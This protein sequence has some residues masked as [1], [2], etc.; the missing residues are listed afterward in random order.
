[1]ERIASAVG[2]NGQYQETIHGGSIMRNLIKTVVVFLMGSLLLACGGPEDREGNSLKAGDQYVMTKQGLERVPYLKDKQG[3]KVEVGKEY[4]MTPA[5]LELIPFL[6]DQSGKR[7]EVG[8]E[9][10]VGPDGLKLVRSRRV[11]GAVLDSDGKPV[12]GVDV[13]LAQTDYKATTDSN[14]L[15]SL[16]FVEGYVKLALGASHIPEWCGVENTESVFLNLNNYPEGWNVGSIKLP[17][18]FAG[19][20]G[21]KITWATVDKSF[22][23]NGDGTVTDVKNGLMWEAAVKEQ[24]VPWN[25]A[26][27]YAENLDLADHSDWRLP[28]SEELAKLH[29]ANAACAWHG[30]SV[31]RGAITVWGSEQKDPS[32]AFIFNV[33]SGKGR[34]SESMDEGPGVNPGALAV[35]QAGK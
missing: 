1:M 18:A 9:Y 7:V 24:E 15:F 5:G 13:E 2:G 31:I 23:D 20:R 6:K 32:S 27:E 21:E 30:P 35:R 19:A 12:P 28:T 8:S 14:G 4:L 17:C 11:H 26:A 34:K 25:K 33:C 3:N 16:P 10:I 29:Q 22:V